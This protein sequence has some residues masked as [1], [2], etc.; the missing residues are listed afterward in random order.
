AP[1]SFLQEPLCCA[2]IFCKELLAQLL[3][4]IDHHLGTQA[5]P[6]RRAQTQKK[7]LREKPGG[8]VRLIC[9]TKSEAHSV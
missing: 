5:Q 8:A 9:C 4:C 2:A 6:E 7:K 1:N 3:I